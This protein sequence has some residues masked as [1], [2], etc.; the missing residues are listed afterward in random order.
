MSSERAGVISTRE[1]A[2]HSKK[3]R[4]GWLLWGQDN[5][6]AEG[7]EGL[8]FCS[9]TIANIVQEEKIQHPCIFSFQTGVKQDI[10]LNSWCSVSHREGGFALALQFVWLYLLVLKEPLCGIRT[11]LSALHSDLESLYHHLHK[12]SSIVDTFLQFLTCLYCWYFY[13]LCFNLEKSQ[14]VCLVFF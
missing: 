3:Q 6:W 10:D 14:V 11:F 4:G 9:Q 7:R 2:G 13:C 12:L 5:P 8:N 1:I